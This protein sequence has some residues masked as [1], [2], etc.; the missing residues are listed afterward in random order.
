[1]AKPSFKRNAPTKTVGRKI[2]IACEGKHTEPLYFKAISRDFR[3]STV[4]VIILTH[5]GTDPLSIVNKLLEERQNKKREKTWLAGDSAWAVF[6][7]D[8]H[9]QKDLNKWKQVIQT[10]KKE[11]IQLAITNPSIEF[12][13]LIHFQDHFA[14][15]SS[16][17]AERGL[18]QHIPNY[19]KSICYYS[20]RLKAKTEE[21]I[22]RA[23]NIEHNAKQNELPEYANPCCSGISQLVQMLLNLG[24]R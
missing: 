22:A 24:D 12:W 9:I 11:N 6:D 14:N 7:G 15:L 1:M 10:A 3:L 4:K 13:Y 8:E 21:A 2:L 20:A 23:N 19:D 18:K 5:D 17:Q 16:S